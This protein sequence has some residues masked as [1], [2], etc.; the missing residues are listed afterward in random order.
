MTMAVLPS[1][2]AGELVTE[3][4]AASGRH[5]HAGIFLSEQ[6]TNDLFLKRQEG[7]VSPVPFEEWGVAG[8]KGSQENHRGGNSGIL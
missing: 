2:V 8:G 3:R 1:R 4:F 6:A 5:D 7:I